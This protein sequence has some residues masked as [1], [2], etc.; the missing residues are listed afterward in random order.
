VVGL[1]ELE[2]SLPDVLLKPVIKAPKR[3]TTTSAG[4]L[5]RKY[6]EEKQ[7]ADIHQV[8]RNSLYLVCNCNVCFMV[9]QW[10]LDCFV[11]LN[12]CFTLTVLFPL[13]NV[14]SLLPVYSNNSAEALIKFKCAY[15]HNDTIKKLS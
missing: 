12:Y 6:R 3:H 9:Y 2:E 4:F 5:K 13:L 8:V 1:L 14:L 10:C 15:V 11:D 7:L